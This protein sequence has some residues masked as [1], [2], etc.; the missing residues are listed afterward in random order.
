[1][2]IISLFVS[3]VNNI[4][5]APLFSHPD[6]DEF[7]LRLMSWYLCYKNTT[8]FVRVWTDGISTPEGRR[9]ILIRLSSLYWPSFR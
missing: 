5:L 7:I 3:A 2:C 6:S 1:L 8:C 4:I 9:A